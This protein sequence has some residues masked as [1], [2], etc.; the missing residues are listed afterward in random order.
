MIIVLQ[1]LNTNM[2]VSLI[3]RINTP[4][5]IVRSV[6]AVSCYLG[7]PDEFLSR[8]L[9]LR[10]TIQNNSKVIIFMLDYGVPV[11]AQIYMLAHGHAMTIIDQ[12]MESGKCHLK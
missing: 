9:L 11:C 12:Y 1:I 5:S 10:A 7:E 8:Y 6:S 3:H 4:V 2:H